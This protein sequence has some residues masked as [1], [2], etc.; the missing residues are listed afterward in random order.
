MAHQ[1][2]VPTVTQQ[3][4]CDATWFWATVMQTSL[5]Q[6]NE[7]KLREVFPV[8]EIEEQKVS[9]ICG[10]LQSTLHLLQKE[11]GENHGHPY[12]C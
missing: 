12:V 4:M 11:R 8:H 10:T 6:E 7:D 5:S 1:P 3:I 9:R 2:V